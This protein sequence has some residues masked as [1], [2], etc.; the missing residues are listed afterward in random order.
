MV[1]FV[2]FFLSGLIPG[3]KEISLQGY[4][5]L[6]L[7]QCVQSQWFEWTSIVTVCL[8]KKKKRKK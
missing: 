5:V 2:L 1:F 6:A 4:F 3:G 8:K 7:L